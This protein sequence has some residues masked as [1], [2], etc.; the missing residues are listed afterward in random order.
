MIA[1]I[2]RLSGVPFREQGPAFLVGAG[3]GMTH[4]VAA[5]FYLLIP[6]FTV[7]LGLSYA[8]AG[9]VVAVLHASSFAAN[10]GSGMAV[11]ITGRR[12]PF[13]ILSLAA[14]GLA[15]LA[16]GVTESYLVLCAMVAVIGAS[17]NLWHPPAIAFLSARYPRNRGYALS[18]HALG[19][20]LG[21]TLAPLAAGALLL[22]LSWQGTASI[23]SVAPLLAAV[24]VAMVLLP[25][26]RPAAG[27]NPGRAMS[28]GDYFRGLK[29][30]A[31]DRPVL[32]LCLMA[33]FRSMTQN[34]LY[35]FL[36]LYLVNVVGA[37]PLVAGAA[38]TAMQVGGVLA[39]PIAGAWSDRVGRRRIVL[40]G[41]TVTTA[42]LF[43]LT[44]VSNEALF[45]GG[46]SV[47]GFALFAIRPVIHSW[48]MDLTPR[49][50]AGSATS[51]MF[52]T[53]SLLSAAVPA[54]GGL[55][56]DRYGLPSVFYL[57]AATIVIANLLVVVLPDRDPGHEG[58]AA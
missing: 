2:E 47:L 26:E 27:A 24:L 54:V 19:A 37:N 7:D 14:G 53:Q 13:Q 36:P 10:F 17:N 45:I 3:H 44:V 50:M 4:W 48:M 1:H 9:M 25:H 39:A 16:F 12:V 56:A 57:L 11:D 28:V 55:L 51:L 46:V 6:Y 40:S 5:F 21:D 20:N 41:L 22:A 18:V 49:E 29:G 15:L 35:V 8:E 33:G 38:M 30:I 23:G 52:G 43:V 58:K 42:V 31:S 34:G 32:G